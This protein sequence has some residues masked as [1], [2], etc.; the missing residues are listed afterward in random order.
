[1]PASP[2][3]SNYS[4]LL[5]DIIPAEAFVGSAPATRNCDASHSQKVAAWQSLCKLNYSWDR[6]KV[7]GKRTKFG[8]ASRARTDDLIVANDGVCQSNPRPEPRLKP[9]TFHYVPFQPKFRLAGRVASTVFP[10]HPEVADAGGPH[11]R[12]LGDATVI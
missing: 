3:A 2:D 12:N 5:V 11:V 6:I 9:S 10:A 8:G 7:C 1:M 4:L